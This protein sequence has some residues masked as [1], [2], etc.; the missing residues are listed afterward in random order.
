MR[1]YGNEYLLKK[2]I[3]EERK[4][5]R[6]N[7]SM[8]YLKLSH[9]IIDTINFSLLIL[10]FVFFIISLDSQKKWSK[11]YKNLSRTIEN[12]NNL[13]DYIS[14]IE[15]F[16]VSKLDSSKNFKKTVPED[17]IYLDNIVY[18]KENFLRR[19]FKY[20]LNGFKNSRY[21]KGY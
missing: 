1:P 8:P 7:I 5:I 20:V 10:V 14:K 18:K 6:F 12:N 16:Y 2:I 11:T 13:I 3:S 9:K 4:G 15:E 21:Q 19:K 17:L